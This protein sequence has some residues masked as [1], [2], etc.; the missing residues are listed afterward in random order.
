MQ[1]D[2]HFLPGLSPVGPV[3][4]HARFDGGSLSSDGGVECHMLIAA[5]HEQPERCPRQFSVLAVVD[6]NADCHR[7]QESAFADKSEYVWLIGIPWCPAEQKPK[8]QQLGNP[9]Y[10]QS[11]SFLQLPTIH[12]HY[13]PHRW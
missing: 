3:E 11:G 6:W 13:Q 1:E 4:I 12:R 2:T 10:L 5:C 8:D 7:L 9:Q